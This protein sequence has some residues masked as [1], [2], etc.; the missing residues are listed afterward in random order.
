[1]RI[2]KVRNWRKAVVFFTASALIFSAAPAAIPVRA[3]TAEVYHETFETG[4]GAAVQSGGARLV[5]ADNKVFEGNA[6][7]N[8]LY[9]SNRANSYDAADFKFSDMGLE[10]GKTYTITVKGYVDAGAVA[11]AGAKIAVQPVHPE[12]GVYGYLAD[13]VVTTGAAFTITGDYTVDTQQHDRIRIQSNNEGAAVP[14]YIGDILITGQAGGGE[15]PEGPPAQPLATVT[16]EN[17]E[18]GGFE[19]RAG[20]ETL[21]VTDEANHTKGGAYALKVEGRADTWHGPSLHVE[22]NIDQGSEY[23]VKAWVRLISPQSSQLQLSTQ[24]GSG[25]AASYIS[26]DAKTIGAGDGWVEFAGTYRYNNVSSEYIT[27]YVESSNNATAS[28][29][30]DDIS[31]EK[32]GSGPVEIEDLTPVKDVYR[33]DFLIGTAVSAEDLTGIRLELLKKHFSIATAGNAMKPDAL[34]P[35][36]GGFAF[37]AADQMV[38]KVLAEGLS[39]HGHTLVWHQQSPAWMNTAVDESGNTVPL[40]REE[41]LRNLRTHIKT[42]VE[43]FGDKVISWDVVNE[44][45]NDNPANPSDWEASLRQ[46][47][48]Y[49]AVGPD[50][51]EQAFLAAREVLDEHPGWNIRLYYNDYNLD[52]HN[53]SQAVYNMVNEINTNYRETHPGELLIDGVGMQGHYSVTTNP[54]NVRLSLERFISLGVEV[55]VTELDIQA[56]SDYQLSEKLA[57]AQG[58]LYAQLF[59]IFK[60]HAAN[61]GRVTIWGMDDG[62]SWRASANPLLFDRNL[63]A[64][65]AYYGVTDPDKF[66]AEHKPTTPEGAKQSTAMYGTP[67]IDG[68]VD[69]IW[70]SAP[71]MQVNQYQMAWQGASGTAKAMWDH[72]NLYVLL[73]VN[74]TQLD[75]GSANAYEQDSVEVFLDENN[76]KTSFYQEDDGQYRVNFDNETSFN[77]AGAAEG[78]ESAVK[79]S[80]TNYTVEMKIPFKTITPANNRKIGFDAQ[81]NDAGNG[82]RISVAAWNDTTGNGYQD[83]S[84]YGELTL[85]GEA[86]PG[87]GN[88]TGTGGNNGDLNTGIPITVDKGLRQTEISVEMPASVNPDGSMAFNITDGVVTEILRHMAA[89]GENAAPTVIVLK[90]AAAAQYGSTGVKLPDGALARL[91]S[92]NED[93]SLKIVSDSWKLEFDN[94]ALK[95]ISGAGT[96]TVEVKVSGLNAGELAGIPSP[97][98]GKIAGRP[99]YEFTVAKGGSEVSDFDGGRVTA[100]I[101]YAPVKG[102]DTDALLVYRLDG[103]NAPAPVRSTYADGAAVFTTTHFSRFAIGY[104][105]VDFEDVGPGD[106][107]Y[108]P[109]VYLGAREIIPPDSLGPK[110]AITRGEAI[111]MLMKAYDIEPLTG[112]GDNFSDAE[113]PYKGYYAKAKAIGLSGGIGDNVLGAS[114]PLTREMLFTLAFNMLSYVG[115]LPETD[116]PVGELSVFSD[117]GALS[118]WSLEAASKLV[119]AGVVTGSGNNAL[120]PKAPAS[121]AETAT[122]LYSLLNR[123]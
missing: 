21:T 51:I 13:A 6:D 104:N 40:G 112:A 29:Y 119:E 116:I 27:V 63:K 73:Q 61:I 64:K 18:K 16:F 65:P 17:G 5:K 94:K 69:S 39:M 49:N 35:T 77:P 107:Y 59:K 14:F 106:Y 88:G 97:A 78:F 71:A 41:A 86:G 93:L 34:Q 45:M 87:G 54:T 32:T 117:Y 122:V 25:S 75:K 120:L 11:P 110:S 67:V 102:E 47:P 66:M 118:D 52:N 100:G 115:E 123:R 109:M 20:T 105:K 92:A 121:R 8:A 1:M 70:S 55:S 103:S 80:G 50:Y 72:N 10:D 24:V 76:G 9:V 91:L 60:D 19:G 85:A 44:A 83:T 2:I 7:G 98:A 23:T 56:G 108:A 111:V 28:F 96:G 62:T 95:T 43:H 42:V 4:T 68:D 26:L 74:D 48:W 113:G 82:S 15:G 89:L 84:V 101:M 90:L 12:K 33:N 3:E 114:I 79:V 53:K 46:S 99:A 81:V 38:D 31:F 36:K 57:E 37:G 22:K 58:Y 30:I